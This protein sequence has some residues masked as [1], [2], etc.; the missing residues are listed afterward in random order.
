MINIASNTH[1]S[2][3]HSKRSAEFT[4]YFSIILVLAIP[5]ATVFWLLEV[6]RKQTLRLRGPL[7]RARAEANRVTPLIFS[8]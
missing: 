5:F 3:V 1:K 8:A 7:A 2:R 6:I 4:F